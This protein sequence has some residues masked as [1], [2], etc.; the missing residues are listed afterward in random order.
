MCPECSGRWW[1]FRRVVKR[2]T[3]VIV[4]VCATLIVAYWWW[5]GLTGRGGANEASDVVLVGDGELM[6][7][8]DVVAR[9]LREEGYSVGEPIPA[10]GWCAIVDGL[11][12][13]R[14]RSTVV[15]Y[16]ATDMT[17]EST[18]ECGD[19]SH[20]ARSIM[21]AVDGDVVV[22]GGVTEG[23]MGEVDVALVDAGARLVDV[24][25]MLASVDG[26]AACEW[27]DD[28]IVVD[29][30]VTGGSAYVIVRDE[31]GLT[32]AGHQRMAR[33]IVAAVQS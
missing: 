31:M 23:D 12:G 29:N 26:A 2:A 1:Y 20:I 8:A 5:P 9:R 6:R 32:L 22:V 14:A 27:W 3:A 19:G 7:G 17:L 28:C 33:M 30:L 21:A 24:S 16:S 18:D 13:A 15:V 25:S 11:S 4:A 10:E